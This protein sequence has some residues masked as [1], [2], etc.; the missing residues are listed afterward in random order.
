MH[1]LAPCPL[2]PLLT[3]VRLSPSLIH[4]KAHPPVLLTHIST[5]YLTLPPPQSPPEKF[6]SV[7][8]PLSERHHECEKLVFGTDGEGSGGGEIVVELIV[9][10]AGGSGSK[11]GVERV[12][13]GWVSSTGTAC[14]L[15]ELESLKALWKKKAIV[16]EVCCSVF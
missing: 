12:L 7:F 6:W 15:Q 1:V 14:Q 5:A 3:E 16:Q 8:A 10:N 9:R 2:I 4:L 13:E 11:R